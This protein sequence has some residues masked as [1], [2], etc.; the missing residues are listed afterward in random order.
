MQ[1]LRCEFLSPPRGWVF[2]PVFCVFLV[3][4]PSSGRA[5][6]I[7]CL[8]RGSYYLTREAQSSCLPMELV[9]SSVL[10]SLFGSASQNISDSSLSYDMF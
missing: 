10:V 1:S 4:F 8:H 3:G 6:F 5:D 2:L 9:L 7:A